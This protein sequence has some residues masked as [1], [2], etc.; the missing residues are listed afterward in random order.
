[1]VGEKKKKDKKNTG[2]TGQEQKYTKV[3]RALIKRH[4]KTLTLDF[5]M[6][7]IKVWSAKHIK[8]SPQVIRHHDGDKIQ[9]IIEEI[10]KRDEEK[11]RCT[12]TQ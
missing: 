1:M 11:K 2:I 7:K 5:T 6:K 3:G 10:R 8:Q 12:R 4:S 9:Q